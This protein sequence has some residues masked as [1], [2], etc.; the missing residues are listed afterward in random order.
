MFRSGRFTR[1]T[2]VVVCLVLVFSSSGAAALQIFDE[3]FYNGWLGYQG[4][5]GSWGVNVYVSPDQ[6]YSGSQSLYVLYNLSWSGLVFERPGG[7][8]TAGN[9]TLRIAVRRYPGSA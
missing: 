3:G 4:Q 1:I 9:N 7:V 6:H 5:T 8:S 2:A